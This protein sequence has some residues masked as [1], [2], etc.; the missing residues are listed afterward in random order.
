MHEGLLQHT[1]SKGGIFLA[2]ILYPLLPTKF[3]DRGQVRSFCGVYAAPIKNKR[4]FLMIASRHY[5]VVDSDSAKS[6][7]CCLQTSLGGYRIM[8]E[9]AGNNCDTELRVSPD[10]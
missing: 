6:G 4:M 5:P 8:E 9:S 3:G 2:T 1:I 7:R 10:T